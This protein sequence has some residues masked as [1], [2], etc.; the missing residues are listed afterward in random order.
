VGCGTGRLALPLVQSGFTVTGADASAEMLSVARAKISSGELEE[1]RLEELDMRSLP[2]REEF[3]ALL[4]VNSAFN[5]LLEDRD[6]EAAL[7]SF[8]QTLR[9]GGL[10]V[11]E[12]INFLSIMREFHALE[13]LH[14]EEEENCVFQRAIRHTFEDVT[15]LFYHD[16]FATVVENGEAQHWRERH[17]LRMF[18][19]N[20]MKHF[21]QDAG[22]KH[23]Q[24]FGTYT[25]R[26]A[27]PKNARRLL[28]TA[29]K[30]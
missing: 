1:L 6:V 29:L 28:L 21:L 27:G 24:C 20:E 15:Q 30:E 22:F 3:D 14:G 18:T 26:Q 5:Y 23:M 10:L 2:Y 13:L 17:T 16:E 9:T 25:D 12:M 7:R 19:H 8:Y 11:L 4:C